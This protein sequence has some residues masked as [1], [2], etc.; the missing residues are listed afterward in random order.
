MRRYFAQALRAQLRGGRLLFLLAVAG[1]ALGVGAVLSIQILNESALGAFA[2][3]VRAL[4]GDAQLSLVGRGPSLPDALL[5]RV[6]SEPGVRGAYPLYR[7]EVALAGERGAALEIVGADLFA[8]ARLPL[9]LA[10]GDVAAVLRTPGWVAVTP[11]LAAE[12]GWARGA[13]IP[14]S[15]GS[16]RAVLEVGALVDFQ[17]VAPLASRRLA[18]MDLAQAQAL[19]GEA[20]RVS[21]IDVV[22]AEGTDPVE[23][24]RRIEERLGGEVRA[25]T[26]EQRVAEAGALLAAFRLNLTALSL[27][28]LFVGG[29]LVHASTQAALSRRREELGVLRCLGATRGQVLALVLGDALLL[30]SLGTAAGIPLGWLVARANV[31]A[32]SATLRNLYLLEGVERVT[33]TPALAGLGVALGL[34][35]ALLGALLPALDVAR[36]DPRVLLARRGDSAGASRAP[37]QLALAAALL[38]AVAAALTLGPLRGWPYAGFALALAL[39]AAVPLCAPLLLRAGARLPAPRRLGASWGAR[40]LSAHLRATAA[41][42]GALAVA[43]S[44]LCGITVMIASFR[45]TV[46][47][48]LEATLRADVYVTTPSWRR[49]QGEATLAPEVVE[50]L[51]HAEG[52]RAIDRLRQLP[53]DANGR[54]VA[55]NG[56]DA[57]LAEAGGRVQLAGGD[58]AAALRAVAREGAVLVSEP[59]A[60][61]AG[62]SV[63][64]RI[65][66]DAGA[67]SPSPPAGER[68]GVRGRSPLFEVAGIYRDYGAERGAVL[69]DLATLAARFGE[70]PLTNVALYLAP[71]VDPEAAVAR[72]R[73]A[74]AG[75]ALLVRSNR[76]L[77]REVLAI[78]EQTFAVTRLLQAMSLVVAVAGV[79]LALLVLARERAAEVAL[80]RSLGA[81]R[82]QVFLVFLGRAAGIALTGLVL[83]AAGGAGLALALVEII[84]PAWFGWTLGLHWPLRTLAGQA[85]LLLAAAVLAGFYPAVRASVTPATELARDAL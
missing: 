10:R 70:G 36:E 77:R 8:P 16:R 49:G 66:L 17:E 53:G 67:T 39:L 85:L 18:V 46:V 47:D 82:R 68:V 69:I 56:F 37:R 81:T 33:F 24:A 11:S 32:V 19:L 1:V 76:T 41:A 6:L 52:V 26:P 60:R 42:A 62:I 29:F 22:A 5:P 65:E 79:T 63:G 78:F 12:R 35:G 13:R 40:D 43:V 75:E 14:V 48:W 34:A 84:N 55:I 71:G 4:S 38:L 83:G 64:D 21:Q 23:L 74:F 7:L 57:A 27:V 50:R 58:R 72:L 3:S 31:R 2:G 73:A 54:P 59:L 61:K 9:D 15:I 44:M 80:L 20:G 45:E 51:A 25:V 30:G 28:S